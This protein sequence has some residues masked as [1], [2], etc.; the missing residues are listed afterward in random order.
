[1]GYI[2]LP[3]STEMPEEMFL[4]T[5]HSEITL[6]PGKRLADWVD[7]CQMFGMHMITAE[8]EN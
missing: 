8:V 5:Y 4:S 3:A 7:P 6:I 2:S 1:M